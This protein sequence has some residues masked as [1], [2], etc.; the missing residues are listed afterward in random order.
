MQMTMLK[1]FTSVPAWAI[2]SAMAIRQV[3]ES[4]ISGKADAT[5][6]TFGLKDM[7]YE[8]DLTPE[9]EKK[10]EQALKGYVKAGRKAQKRAEKKRVVPETTPE[11]REEIRAWAKDQ[12]YELAD[13]GRIPKHIFAAYQE[14]HSDEAEDES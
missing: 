11:E 6:V 2:L 10:L 1:P 13:F 12:G 7:W 8:I 3:V 5:T 14:A 9:E 4:D